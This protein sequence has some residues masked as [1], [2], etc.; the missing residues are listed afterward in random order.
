MGT[1]SNA[2]I[3]WLGHSTFLIHTPAG[4]RVLVEAFVQSC[5][6]CPA[7]YHQLEDIDLVLLTHGHEDHIADVADIATRTGAK[8]ACM[9]ELARWLAA[10]GGVP[11]SQLVEFNKG[12]TVELAGIRTTMVDAKHSSSAPDG[13]YAGEPAGFVI[14][15]EDGYRIYHAGDTSVFGDM[16]TIGELYRPDLAI[17]P[18]GGHYTMDPREAAHAVRLLGVRDVLGMHYGTFPPLTGRPSHLREVVHDAVTIHEL[19]PGMT[20]GGVR[21]TA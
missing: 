18:I 19:E 5:P 14:E 15:L 11:E 16:S 7:E 6:T 21:S 4:K 17:L 8:V 9:V 20:L 10:K 12:G 3:T 13:S 2:A 1:P